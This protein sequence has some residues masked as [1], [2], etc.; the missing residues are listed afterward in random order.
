M[1]NGMSRTEEY[2]M[3]GVLEKIFGNEAPLT[4]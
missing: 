3:Y 4:T 1:F 2:S